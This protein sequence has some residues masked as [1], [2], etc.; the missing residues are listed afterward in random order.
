MPLI[1][2][3]NTTL[4][5][6]RLGDLSGALSNAQVKRETRLDVLEDIIRSLCLFDTNYT[7]I[8]S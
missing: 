8:F 5:L 2:Y 4:H 1:A 6:V 7:M 3:G